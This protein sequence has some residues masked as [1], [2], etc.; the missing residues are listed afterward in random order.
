MITNKFKICR[1]CEQK[2]PLYDFSLDNNRKDKKCIYCLTCT[3]RKN[4]ESRARTYKPVPRRIKD[5]SHLAK[6]SD[7][8]CAYMAGLVDGEGCIVIV[9]EKDRDGR[10]M[11]YRLQLS[12]GNT[13][14]G[15]IDW[16]CYKFGGRKHKNKRNIFYWVAVS[17][18]ATAIL[19]TI[20]K[21]LHIKKK[22]ALLALRF[23][24]FGRGNHPQKKIIKKE[25]STLNQR[26]QI[27]CA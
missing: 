16:I 9:E 22:R 24:R 13:N 10:A 7:V 21:H 27:Q 12:V 2:K 17:L 20:I 15:L 25:I 18:D 1:C 5:T 14:E 8:D 3:R 4:R 23:M 26:R 11:S 6:L 19:K